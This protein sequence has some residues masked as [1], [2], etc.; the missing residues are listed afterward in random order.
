MREGGPTTEGGRGGRE[1]YIVFADLLTTDQVEMIVDDG[2][3]KA[4]VE[5]VVRIRV[6][7]K[8]MCVGS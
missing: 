1:E 6:G 8:Y 3:V 7:R 4:L 5:F 2:Q